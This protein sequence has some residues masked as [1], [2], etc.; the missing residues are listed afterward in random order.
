MNLILWRHAEAREGTP[1]L[2]RELT[3]R[4]VRDAQCVAGWLVSHL[5]QNA[6]IMA[7]PALRTQQT[8]EALQ[9]PFSVLETLAP[10]STVADILNV[11]GWPTSRGTVLI[12]GHQPTLGRVA[13]WL[14][15]GIEAD[16]S[17]KKANVWWFSYRVREGSTQTFLRAVISPD[18]L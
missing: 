5:P 8:A 6:T 1:D 14:L 15:S 13:A 17:I 7:S 9:M 2:A 18:I 11:A 12:V 4:G 3:Q 16:W 10:D